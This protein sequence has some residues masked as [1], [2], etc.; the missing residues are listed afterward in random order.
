MQ[1]HVNL[2]DLV[3]RFPTNIYEVLAKIGVGVDAAE[4]EP[5]KVHL[6]FQPWD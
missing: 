4:N 6:I 3:K 5:L 1:K 2:V